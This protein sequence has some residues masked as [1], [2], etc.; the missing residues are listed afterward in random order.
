MGTTRADF[1]TL[2]PRLAEHYDV[3]ALDLPGHGESSPLEHR[4]TVPALA[5]AVERDLETR[6]LGRVHVLGNSLG[7]RVALELARRGRALSVV[8]LAPSGMGSPP[9]RLYQAMA[10]AG[11]RLAMRALRPLLPALARRRFGRAALLAPLRARPWA[12]TEAEALSLRGGFADAQRFWDTLWWAVLADVPTGLREV[13]CPVTLV[14]GVL[15]WVAPGQAARYAV[16]ISGSWFEPLLLAGHAPQSDR[17]GEIVR[18][19]RATTQRAV[20]A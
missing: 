18:I 8:A 12:A 15:D 17:P 6:G 7:G 10:M 4:H 13:S 14:Q 5:S 2:M 16:V 1:A 3:L 11:G 20:P 9:E 19:V